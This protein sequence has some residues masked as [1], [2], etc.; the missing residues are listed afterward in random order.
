MDNLVDMISAI[1][2]SQR[3]L[4]DALAVVE[5]KQITAEMAAKRGIERGTLVVLN[6]VSRICCL[7]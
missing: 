3:E 7:Y 1:V 6:L 5:R 4:R 2:D